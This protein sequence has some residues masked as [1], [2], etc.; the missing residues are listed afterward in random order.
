MS[1]TKEQDKTSEKELSKMEIS[2]LS[3]KEFKVMVIRMLTE[4]GRRMNE[5]SRSFYIEIVNIRKNE[6]E[7]KNKITEMKNTPDGIN[8]RLDDTEE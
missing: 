8:N 2:N 1:Q 3:Y 5:Y 7:L 4:L 6:S